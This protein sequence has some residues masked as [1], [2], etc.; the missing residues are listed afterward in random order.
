MEPKIH[1]WIFGFLTRILQCKILALLLLH[2][3]V[4]LF[5]AQ[6][7]PVSIYIAENAKILAINMQNL[8]GAGCC[9]CPA[10]DSAYQATTGVFM[11][12]EFINQ[13]AEVTHIEMPG[14]QGIATNRAYKDSLFRIIYSGKDERSRRWL[15][16]LYNAITDEPFR[17]SEHCQ[18]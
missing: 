5:F 12:K 13:T 16:S 10:L 7:R 17:A 2:I 18:S 9:V 6:F 14:F 15:L 11:A 3:H 8:Q 1:P 4:E